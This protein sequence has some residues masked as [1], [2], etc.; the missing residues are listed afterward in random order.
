MRAGLHVLATLALLPYVLLAT[1]FVLLEQAIGDGTLSALLATL[2]AQVLWLVPWGLLGF[3]IGTAL[4]AALGLHPASRWVGGLVLCVLA[5]AAIAVVTV[6]PTAPVEV[7]DLIFLLPCLLVAVY[8]AWTVIAEGPQ[9]ARRTPAHDR[10][11]A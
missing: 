2:L 9:R 8:G 3:L 4:L 1:A 5:L 11:G 7:E 6:K 10:R